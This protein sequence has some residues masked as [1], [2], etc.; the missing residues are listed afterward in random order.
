MVEMHGEFTH[1]LDQKNRLAVPAK[2]REDLGDTFVLY[3][4]RNGDRC[5][6]AYPVEI[7]QEIMEKLNDQPVSY[8]LTRDQRFAHRFSDRID[9]DKQGRFTIPARFMEFAGLTKEVF[10]LGA[11]KRVE[12]WDPERFAE[13]EQQYLAEEE[14]QRIHL[15]Y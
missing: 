10:I 14:D 1:N 3:I 9:V 12:F 15:A 6:F 5:L 4:P 2:I 11:G 7:W 8:Q 13:M